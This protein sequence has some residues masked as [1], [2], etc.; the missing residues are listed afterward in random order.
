MGIRQTGLAL[1]ILSSAFAGDVVGDD[2]GERHGVPS[3]EVQEFFSELG[4][5]LG[6]SLEEAVRAVF[7]AGGRVAE[8][9][10]PVRA[11]ILAPSYESGPAPVTVVR[12]M[13]AGHT[14]LGTPCFSE[15]RSSPW[16]VDGRGYFSG[17]LPYG[18]Y[19][20]CVLMGRASARFPAFDFGPQAGFPPELRLFGRPLDVKVVDE[21]GRPISGAEVDLWSE[22]AGVVVESRDPDNTLTTDHLGRIA[23]PLVP[24]GTALLTAHLSC[25][26]VGETV[27]YVGSGRASLSITVK[28]AASR[29][30]ITLPDVLVA[31]D[32]IRHVTVKRSGYERS[33][34]VSNE[35]KLLLWLPPGPCKLS[36]VGIR[37]E[38]IVVTVGKDIEVRCRPAD[39]SQSSR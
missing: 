11:R 36:S 31:G 28:G 2:E 15:I 29:V 1:I 5:R 21:R 37:D 39:G 14:V 35:G 12:V 38:D 3:P 6:R 24:I 9:S 18:R 4:Q 19:F 34:D 33:Y 7:A 27:V 26:A 30:F 32:R 22:G 13:R 16:D 20:L 10:W 25:E 17:A 23:V 8:E